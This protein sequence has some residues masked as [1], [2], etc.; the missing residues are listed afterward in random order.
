MKLCA[1]TPFGVYCISEP[2]DSEHKTGWAQSCYWL[3]IPEYKLKYNPAISQT[4]AD[5]LVLSKIELD[6]QTSW[7]SSIK[8]GT[9]VS[10][11]DFL[12]DR[13]YDVSKGSLT[14]SNSH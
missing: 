6:G 10:F 9:G 2:F 3:E 7:G 14:M 5:G 1:V 4:D 13:P 12:F 8:E 11:A